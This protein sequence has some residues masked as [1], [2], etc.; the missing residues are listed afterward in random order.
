MCLEGSNGNPQQCAI[1]ANA[2][3][4]EEYSVLHCGH[5]FHQMCLTLWF[6]NNANCP[7]CGSCDIGDF[8]E[9]YQK[10]NKV[11]RPYS[12]KCFICAEAIDGNKILVNPVACDCQKPSTSGKDHIAHA[13]LSTK[14]TSRH[15]LVTIRNTL[16]LKKSI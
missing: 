12:V 4:S 14:F 3:C 7:L 6:V 5:S 13:A 11:Y 10:I 15:H 1:C 16:F 9:I 2:F 8:T